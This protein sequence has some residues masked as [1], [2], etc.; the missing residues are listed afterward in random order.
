MSECTYATRL[1]KMCGKRGKKKKKRWDH[2]QIRAEEG[3]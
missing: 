2:K 3:E 1:E